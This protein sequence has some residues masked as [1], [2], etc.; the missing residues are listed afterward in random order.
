MIHLCLCDDEEAVLT[1]CRQRISAFARQKG[2]EIQLREFQSGES[3]LFT[4]EENPNSADILIMDM[5]MKGVSGIAA[6]KKLRELGYGG[7]VIFLT[8]SAE[9]ALEAYSVE[10]LNYILKNQ[11]QDETFEKSLSKAIALVED[12]RA[13]NL[14]FKNSVGASLMIDL[15]QVLYMESMQRK[16]RF[17]TTR[18]I[19][20]TCA[21]L[22]EIFEQVK[23][24]DFVRC[25]KSCLVNLRFVQS[26]SRGEI[27]MSDQS[28]LPIGRKYGENF[29]NTFS[30]YVFQSGFSEVG[31]A[32]KL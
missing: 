6:T 15:R 20:E 12:T 32:A 8:S 28:V 7:V 23:D 29:G 25:H 2:L 4:L 27:T 26:F 3:L 22:E 31:G 11:L 21:T 30:D 9:Y 1:L 17:H 5:L 14:V 16:I 19:Q 18:G 13:Q 24:W 10:P